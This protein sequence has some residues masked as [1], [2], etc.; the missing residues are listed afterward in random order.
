M[1]L[2][3]SLGIEGFYIAVHGGVKDLSAP[4]LFFSLKGEKFFHAVLDIEPCH[5]A[6]KFESFVISGLGKW[7]WVAMLSY[8]LSFVMQPMVSVP[9]CTSAPPFEQVG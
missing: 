7:P 1:L 8:G 6:L 4:K 2:C 5:L 9:L 3:A